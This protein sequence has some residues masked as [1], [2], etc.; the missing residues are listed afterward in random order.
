ML[1]VVIW[2]KGLLRW[3]ERHKVQISSSELLQSLLGLPV[4]SDFRMSLDALVVFLNQ[5]EVV[6]FVLVNNELVEKG[7]IFDK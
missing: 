5:S 4:L 7:K 6:P 1:P 3:L 2:V